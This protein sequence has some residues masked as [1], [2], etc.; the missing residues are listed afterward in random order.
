MLLSQ[1]SPVS[2]SFTNGQSFGYEIIIYDYIQRKRNYR[3]TEAAAFQIYLF[4]INLGYNVR[5]QLSAFT[6][7]SATT[8]GFVRIF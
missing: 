8:G 2:L 4:F 7:H 6:R 5:I 3:K 1:N